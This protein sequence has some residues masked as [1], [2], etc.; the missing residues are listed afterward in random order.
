MGY[1]NPPWCLIA[2][3]LQKVQAQKASLVIVT[4][5]WP[6]QAWFPQ[7]VAMLSDFPILPQTPGILTPSPNCGGVIQDKMPQPIVCK[8]SG[9]ASKQVEFQRKL[10]SSSWLHGAAR[11]G[12]TMTLPGGNG[13]NVVQDRGCKLQICDRC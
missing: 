13:N 3:V 1:A 12:Q 6:T 8:V 10:L 5:L 11:Q 2:R 4:T 7:L 9:N